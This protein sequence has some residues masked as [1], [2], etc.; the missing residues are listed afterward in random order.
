MLNEC[1]VFPDACIDQSSF[2]SESASN[3]E[4]GLDEMVGLQDAMNGFDVP[5]GG[6]DIS[7]CDFENEEGNPENLRFVY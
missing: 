1:L 5:V 7:M 3:D 6:L 2:E 4:S